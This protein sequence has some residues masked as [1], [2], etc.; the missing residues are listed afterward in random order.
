MTGVQTC[1]LP[2]S[3][4]APTTPFAANPII[5]L[6]AVLAGIL[7]AT[8][9]AWWPSREATD[10]DLLEGLSGSPAPPRH[11]V[12]WRFLAIV[13][14]LACIATVSQLLVI[15]EVL[16]PR[17]AVPGGIVLLLA[18]VAVTPLVLPWIARGLAALAPRRLR[19]ETK[20]ALEQILRQPVRTALTSGV[21]VV[22]V[23]NGVGLGHAI[24]D[25]VDD[26]MD[27][28]ARLMRADWVLMHAG[29]ASAAGAAE[30]GQTRSA[31]A[32]VAGLPGVRG[33]NGVGVAVGREIGRAHV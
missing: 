8:A 27:W 33:V 9:A 2:I 1:A 4:Q 30:G 22:A 11:G 23:T 32:E 12:S 28:Y 10:A 26:V 16:P 6:L 15:T 19:I 24:R 17:A 3:L 31:E 21:L 5:V 18:F 7:V 25:N 20:L 14:A 29:V 13:L